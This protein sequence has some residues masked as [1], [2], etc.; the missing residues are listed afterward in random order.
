MIDANRTVGDLVIYD[1]S[2]VVYRGAVPAE[3]PSTAPTLWLRIPR[4]VMD[5]PDLD[6]DGRAFDVLIDGSTSSSHREASDATHHTLSI[7][8]LHTTGIVDVSG[9]IAAD[10]WTG[11]GDMPGEGGSAVPT[12]PSATP[13]LDAAPAS[14]PPPQCTGTARC[15][16]GTITSVP[17]ADAIMLSGG[18]S[19]RLALVS[20]PTPLEAGGKQA[21]SR[22]ASMCPTGTQIMVDGDDLG[23][24]STSSTFRNRVIAEAYCNDGGT[25]SIQDVLAAS[26]FGSIDRATCDTS[27]FAS[28]TRA[29]GACNTEARPL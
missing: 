25:V 29:A 15:L 6:G 28:R 1:H 18:M 16:R 20:V 9:P 21:R 27:E 8:V 7:L 10:C 22:V 3:P 12:S 23:A 26:G 4:T 19:V 24:S 17:A 11:G 2:I 5:P 13:P 14:L